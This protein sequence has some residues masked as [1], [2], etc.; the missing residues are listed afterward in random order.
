MAPPIPS[1]YQPGGGS[2]ILGVSLLVPKVMVQKPSV[3]T[4]DH[5]IDNGDPREQITHYN[6]DPSWELEIYDFASSI[7]NDTPS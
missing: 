1:R 3:A 4:V 7:I 2:V 5:E 6:R